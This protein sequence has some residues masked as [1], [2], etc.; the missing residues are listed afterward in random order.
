MRVL[1]E[2]VP[3]RIITVLQTQRVH[4]QIVLRR[5]IRRQVKLGIT[6]IL[7]VVVKHVHRVVR[8]MQV[9]H[10]RLMVRQIVVPVIKRAQ[11]NP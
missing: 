11:I 7:M 3:I 10:H 1:L 9:I 5:Q 8:L 4:Q 2:H 6:G